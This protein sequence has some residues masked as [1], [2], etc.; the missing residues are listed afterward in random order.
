MAQWESITVREAISRMHNEIMVLPVI[1]RNLVWEEDKMELL[2]DSL[3]RKNSFGSI[4]CVEE[5]K[6]SVPLFAHRIFRKDST[7]AQSVE[8][9]EVRHSTL[10]IIDGQQRLQSFYSGLCGTYEGKTLYYDLF[11]NPTKSDYDYNF[12]FASPDKALS[13]NNKEN[14]KFGEYLWY[15]A[16]ALFSRLQQ[17]EDSRIVAREIIQEKGITDREQEICIEDNVS[18]FY[19]RI[20]A[21]SSIGLSKVIAHMSKD[22]NEDRQRI[23][24]MFQRLNTGGTRLSS[25]DLVASS[26]KSFNYRMEKFLDE[27]IRENGSMGLDQDMLIKMLLVL[28]DKPTKSIADISSMHDASDDTEFATR[29][30]ERIK[31]TLDALKKFLKASGNEEWFNSVVSRSAIPLYFIA[32]HIFWQS[33]N[34][35]EIRKLFDKF[36]TK[37]KNFHDMSLWL[38]LSLLNNVFKRGCGWDPMRTGMNRIHEVMF[39]NK[40]RDFPLNELLALYKSRLHKFFDKDDITYKSL[41]SLDQEY[42]FYMIYG[43]RRSTIRLEDKDHVQPRALLEKANVSPL[44]ISSLGN[45]QYLDYGTNRGEKNSLELRDWIN[46]KVENKDEYLSRHLIPEDESLWT[47]D[48]FTP[49]LNA[50]LRLI[51][52]KIKSML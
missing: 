24:E 39:R 15:S 17:T 43:G 12:K 40:G 47:S 30:I 48:K 4:I 32:Y 31:A 28:H 38:K 11:S 26:L 34:P 21:D 20:F 52:R 35:V 37:D 10:L 41:D 18:D 6:G 50:R 49:F 23:A 7:Q 13:P 16:S 19:H 14:L 8:Y 51:A 1:Q 5:E 45:L 33:D 44:N 25:Y 27:V 22:V 29:N 2:F 46:S 9:D 36:D 3:F 42:I